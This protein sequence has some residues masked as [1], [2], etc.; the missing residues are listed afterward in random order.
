MKSWIASLPQDCW[1]VFGHHQGWKHPSLWFPWYL[2]QWHYFSKST[3]THTDMTGCNVQFS[4]SED[5]HMNSIL[6]LT[7]SFHGKPLGIRAFLISILWN[8]QK[9]HY[10]HMLVGWWI[11]VTHYHFKHTA[12]SVIKF[13]HVYVCEWNCTLQWKRHK[14][15][16]CAKY[17][18]TCAKQE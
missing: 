4:V 3:H 10:Y 11:C 1:K 9:V 16:C 6:T 5:V 15:R 17:S 18:V 13:H 14:G 2:D 7:R 12:L 8:L